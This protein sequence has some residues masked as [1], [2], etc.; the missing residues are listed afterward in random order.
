MRSNNACKSRLNVLISVRDILSIT[1]SF[2]VESPVNDLHDLFIAKLKAKNIYSKGDNSYFRLVFFITATVF[3]NQN[4]LLVI[5][6]VMRH[7]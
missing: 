3:Q 4:S 7:L 2:N 6:L 1:F 5:S